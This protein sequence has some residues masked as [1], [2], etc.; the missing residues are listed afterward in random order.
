MEVEAQRVQEREWVETPGEHDRLRR[1]EA[2]EAG[3]FQMAPE[4][5]MDEREG[6]LGCRP[7]DELQRRATEAPPDFVALDAIAQTLPC[8]DEREPAGLQPDLKGSVIQKVENGGTPAI[9]EAE[10]LRESPLGA[11]PEP[12]AVMPTGAEFHRTVDA[13]PGALGLAGLTF[14]QLGGP[15]FECLQ[16]YVWTR[17]SK[18]MPMA[19]DSIYPL[20]LEGYEGV[21]PAKLSWLQA[22]LLGLNSLYGAGGTATSCPSELQKRLVQR[23]LGFLDRFWDWQETVP[24]TS[25]SQLFKVKGVDYRGE[26]VKLARSF[27]WECISEALPKEV[28]TLEL[29]SF[30]TGRCRFYIDEFENFLLPVEE[31]TI[32]RQPR[33]L[34]DDEHWFAVCQGLLRSGICGVLPQRLLH[35]VQGKPLLNGLFAVSKNE[36]TASGIELCRLIM[37]LVPLNRLCRSLR[38]DVGTLPSIAG[39]SSFFLEEGEIAVMSSEDIKCF[40]Y[41]FRIPQAWQRFMGFAKVVPPQLVP[42]EFV[43]E[44][45]YLVALV[46]PMGFINSVGLAQ[47]IHRNVVR[48]SLA[49]QNPNSGGERELRR[50]RPAPFHQDVFRVYL[51]N[52][53]Q[54]RKVDSNLVRDVEG[55]PSAE[56]LA[57]RQQYELL[58]LPRHPKKAVESSCVAEVQG[59]LLGGRAG[60]AYAKPDKVLKYLG[61]G[62]ELVRRGEASMKE[63]QVV[64]G[65][66]VYITMFRRALLCSL[67][68]IWLQIESLKN[69]PPVVRLPLTR[70]VKLE[71]L[72]FMALAPLAQMSFRLPMWKQVTA[73][74]AS[75]TGGGLCCSSGL[76]AYGMAAQTASLRGE[77]Q[78]P[79]EVVEVLTIGLFDGIGAL[80][81]AADV[82]QLPMAG[83]IS[84]ECNP[85]ANRVLESAFPGSQHVEHV[86]DVSEAEVQRWSCEYSSVGVVL[87]GAGPPCQ[88]VSKL[89]V[90]RK[91]SQRGVRSSLYKEVPRVK[92]LVEKHFPWAQVHLFLESVA[93]M[94]VEDRAAMSQD[95]GLLPRRV[96]SSGVSLA[97]RP[98]LYWFTWELCDEPGLTAAEP[99]G[100]HWA[101]L[102]E[103]LLVG[104]IEQKSFLQAGWS[105]PA[106]QR[107]ATFTT[108]RPSEKPGRRPAGLQSCDDASL[109][110]WREDKHR[111]PPYQYKP[112]YCVHHP[113]LPCRPAT[114]VEREAILGFPVDYTVQCVKKQDQQK[115]WA[116]DVRKS[117]LG[118]SWSVPV[119]C[120]LIKQLFER[121]GIVP[122]TSVQDLLNR[123][124]PGEGSRLQ[125]VLQRPPLKRES[126]LTFPEA[127]LTRRLAGLVSVKGEDLLLQASSEQLVR[128]HRL[129]TSIPGKLWK[130][131]AVA[132]WS[133]SGSKEHINVLEMRAVLTSV[134]Y[135]IV[136]QKLQGH[137]LLHLTD[138]LVV[139]HSLSR[140]RSS[141]R[142]LRRT[143]MRINA[144]LLTAD[145]HPVWCYIHTSQNPADRPSRRVLRR[146]WAKVKNT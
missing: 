139:L 27:T 137:K 69:F 98:R 109:K 35:H 87:I 54:I 96:D 128:H 56:Q 16:P 140:G 77:V 116:L 17:H 49:K 24:F 4:T 81:V 36:Y 136:K 138:S 58:Q 100:M 123:L 135:W 85:H 121:L 129:R 37:N 3:S 132:G 89:N 92:E 55:L 102:Q 19:K 93:S 64:A 52:W 46:L 29:A 72:R 42:S 78:E 110:R 50:D 43:G 131:R 74:D 23:L 65:G 67:N 53:D 91:G 108:S 75:L 26:E 141:S 122:R 134:K 145:L 31:Q 40:Y 12:P 7:R 20:P 39:F 32:G 90:D 84:V 15:L 38:G 95:L 11:C 82:L 33:V 70:E 118:N 6:A 107:L 144:M 2:E 146:K 88:D 30:C 94:D 124:V 44:P 34:V 142:K 143:I 103:I 105:V 106:G 97:R 111:Y 119:V 130:W 112:E 71:L 57:L 76:T 14:S 127:G 13:E 86:Q 9:E 125:M 115:E 68:A 60:V 48:W 73:S 104:E 25:F 117:L 133:W 126:A 47:H 83:H 5:P 120:C 28:G 61:L 113:T 8:R 66:F 101:Q 22:L 10:V 1:S 99:V 62:W 63:L 21:H 80:R 59:A 41:L 45:C 18:T 51:D 79:M 114:V